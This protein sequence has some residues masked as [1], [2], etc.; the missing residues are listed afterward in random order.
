MRLEVGYSSLNANKLVSQTNIKMEFIFNQ[1]TPT[2]KMQ[3]VAGSERKWGDFSRKR[4]ANAKQETTDKT[5]LLYK[6]LG[7]CELGDKR[8]YL[9]K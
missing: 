5:F 9:L 1:V 4:K 7:V 8:N 2:T 6:N 3:G